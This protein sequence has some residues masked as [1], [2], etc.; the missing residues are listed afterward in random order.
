MLAYWIWLAQKKLSDWEKNEL[1]QHFPAPEDLYFSDDLSGLSLTEKQTA[2]LM[3][4]DLQEA[5]K[6]LSDCAKERIHILTIRDAAYPR[7]LKNIPDPP[8]VLYYK[9]TLPNFDGAPTISI[10]GTRKA[11][12][13]GLSVAKRLGYRIAN[14]GG[15]VV[16]GAAEGIDALAMLGALSTGQSVVGILGIGVDVIYPRCNRGLYRDLERYGCLIS[17][18]P[19]GTPPHK[20]N[21]PRRNRIISGLADGVLVV[22]APQGS[23]ALITA[24]RAADQGRDVFVVPGNV[25]NPLCAGSNALLRDGAISIS[26]GWELLS[27]YA[28]RYP[29]KLQKRPGGENLKA[30]PEE[31]RRIEGATPAKVA[32]NVA[33]PEKKKVKEE[34]KSKKTIDKEDLPLYIDGNN[35]KPALTPNEQ[36][37]TQLLAQG[38]RLVDDIMAASDLSPGLVLA[39]LTMLE[40]KGVVK[41][42]PGRRVALN[43]QYH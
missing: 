17:E 41:S 24:R 16:S 33:F 27:E 23:G 21:F 28:Q 18:F 35:K 37:L 25:D 38:E 14:C 8:I 6:I 32:Q 42:L 12:G 26:D 30:Y 9:G 34:K 13:Y 7:Q 15:I 39:T 10:V 19:P 1:L 22:E 40:V 11:S 3:D 5:E 36:A 43:E 29:D 4:K 2:E 31:V 20:W